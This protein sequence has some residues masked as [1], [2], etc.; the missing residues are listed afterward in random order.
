MSPTAE[1]PRIRVADETRSLAVQ[2]L[3]ANLQ[4]RLNQ[5]GDRSFAGKHEGLGTIAEEYH[6]L[7][8]AVRAHDPSHTVNEAID[9]AVGCLWLVASLLEKHPDL[10]LSYR[11]VV[12]R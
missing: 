6:E 1:N 12:K 7:V 8:E 5:H 4:N 9:V 11:E 3:L 10:V 2:L